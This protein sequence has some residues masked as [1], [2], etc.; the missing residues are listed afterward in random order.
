MMVKINRYKKRA[1]L[2]K[3]SPR[4]KLQKDTA[5]TETKIFKKFEQSKHLNIFLINILLIISKKD[6][7]IKR[8]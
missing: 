3:R 5:I 2:R 1:A 7:L 6:K 8:P 4:R